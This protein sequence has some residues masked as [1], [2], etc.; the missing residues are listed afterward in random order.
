MHRSITT[1]SIFIM[2]YYVLQK[3]PYH[4]KVQITLSCIHFLSS[5]SFSLFFSFLSKKKMLV[6]GILHPYNIPLLDFCA[7]LWDL[8]A[9]LLRPW[10]ARP[11]G[12]SRRWSPAGPSL[13]EALPITVSCTLRFC[14]RF[15]ATNMACGV[16]PRLMLWLLPQ[17]IRPLRLPLLMQ[18][19]FLSSWNPCQRRKLQRLWNSLNIW[20]TFQR[21]RS[22]LRGR[23]RSPFRWLRELW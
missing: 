12:C 22:P 23:L 16:W 6:R 20:M 14:W 2:S 13:C 17:W 18:K 7:L 8:A 3:L 11:S 5:L 1:S 19:P 4:C 21:S 9:A 15:V 10:L